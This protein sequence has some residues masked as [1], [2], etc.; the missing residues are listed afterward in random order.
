MPIKRK[1]AGGRAL[2]ERVASQGEHEVWAPEA[3]VPA[4]ALALE[5]AFLLECISK[6]WGFG[7]INGSVPGKSRHIIGVWTSL[8]SW[9]A[10]RAKA[11]GGT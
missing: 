10:T 6:K 2:F 4:A 3:L 5:L 11:Q 7:Y 8:I 1:K 9:N